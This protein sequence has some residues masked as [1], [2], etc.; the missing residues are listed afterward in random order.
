MSLLLHSKK[1]S[2]R[3]IHQFVEMIDADLVALTRR[4]KTGF[5][6]RHSVAEDLVNHEKIPVLVIGTVG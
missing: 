6:V 2:R 4:D 1:I 3:G 5:L